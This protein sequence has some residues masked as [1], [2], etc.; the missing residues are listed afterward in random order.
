MNTTTKQ[1]LVGAALQAGFG[2][3]LESAPT[4]PTTIFLKSGTDES[5]RLEKDL[6]LTLEASIIKVPPKCKAGRAVFD[7]VKVEN[8]F[9]S[10]DILSIHRLV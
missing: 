2:F 9:V 7:P 5:A 3:G 1:V 8:E 4:T 10:Q 6:S